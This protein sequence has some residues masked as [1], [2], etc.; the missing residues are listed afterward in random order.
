MLISHFHYDRIRLIGRVI[1]DFSPRRVIVGEVPRYPTKTVNHV[2]RRAG[3][4][5]ARV[6]TPFELQKGP[7]RI[8]VVPTCRLACSTLFEEYG[9]FY[10]WSS[11]VPHLC[12]VHPVVAMSN[13]QVDLAFVGVPSSVE[14]LAARIYEHETGLTV[15][16]ELDLSYLVPH[17][18]SKML[19]FKS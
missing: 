5:L 4:S 19:R 3:S 7:A 6:D 9:F 13:A 14:P 10:A 16:S 15:D 1:E 17:E 11:V 2:V 18:R 12:P 8:R